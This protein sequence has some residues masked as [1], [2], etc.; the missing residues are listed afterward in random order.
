[1]EHYMGAYHVECP[2]R[3]E[4]IYAM[5]DDHDMV[6]RLQAISPSPVARDV[7]LTVHDPTY[8]DRLAST[9][10]KK[11]TY[12]D[13]D[14]QTSPGSY[15]AALIAA[16][17]LCEAINLVYSGALNNAFALVRP[18]GHHA[19][20]LRAMGFCLFNNIAVGARYAQKHLGL[21]R[22]LIIDWDVHHGNGTQ[23]A[24]EEDFSVLYFSTHQYPFYPG[25][26]S[27]RE[28]GRGH[29]EGFTV[30][31]PLPPGCGDTE[32]LGLF[33]KVLKPIALEY[34]PQLIL[35]SAGFDCYGGDPLGGM[36]VTCEG[37]AGMTRAVMEIARSC[38]QGKVV[39]TLEGGYNIEGQRDS[40][41]HVLMELAGMSHTEPSNL[42]NKRASRI[43]DEL[44]EKAREIHGRFWSGL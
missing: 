20:R 23:H 14:T 11:Y 18:P 39:L 8:V 33:D 41:K 32:Y 4:A 13:P 28:A 27:F 34:A 24:F 26:G 35:V 43:L 1:M 19:E 44:T 5:L 9:A 2:E 12:L 42:P 30:N 21:H 40:V 7:L 31:I 22:I 36:N 10:G 37:F 38:C 29:G 25:T 16:G 6:N 15:E 3:L 17:G